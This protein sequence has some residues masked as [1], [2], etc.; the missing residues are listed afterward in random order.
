MEVDQ[1]VFK[2][3]LGLKVADIQQLERLQPTQLHLSHQ[4]TKHQEV[5]TT[6]HHKTK[7]ISQLAHLELPATHP[8]DHQPEQDSQAHKAVRQ[9]VNLTLVPKPQA[10]DTQ[11]LK[12]HQPQEA[13][14]TQAQVNKPNL[15]DQQDQPPDV[16]QLLVVDLQDSGQLSKDQ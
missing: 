14:H 15:K 1:V 11:E 12:H 4:T 6:T 16:H 13:L 8:K 9:E 5:A 2:V 3:P 10:Q 7:M